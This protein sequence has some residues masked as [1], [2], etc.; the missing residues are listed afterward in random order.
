VILHAAQLLAWCSGVR[1]LCLTFAIL[2]VAW[3]W[4]AWDYARHAR[5]LAPLRWYIGYV[6]SADAWSLR[7]LNS[8]Y[9]QERADVRKRSLER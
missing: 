9:A 1:L 5:Y 7:A 4:T 2:G 8:K 6:P 3:L